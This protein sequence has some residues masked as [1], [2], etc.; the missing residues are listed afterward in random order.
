MDGSNSKVG[1]SVG[2]EVVWEGLSE[3]A[4][5]R[6]PS[7]RALRYRHE[8]AAPM[9]RLSPLYSEAMSNW[10]LRKVSS[11]AWSLGLFFEPFYQFVYRLDQ[12]FLAEGC[13]I[14]ISVSAPQYGVRIGVY[15]IQHENA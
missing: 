4:S 15:D 14:S 5:Y 1:F 6:A 7:D 3:S 8:K 12:V 13:V 2:V 9:A 10:I 11:W